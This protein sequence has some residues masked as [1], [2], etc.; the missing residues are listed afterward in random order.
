MQCVAN[1]QPILIRGNN[2]LESRDQGEGHD[3]E[4]GHD[5]KYG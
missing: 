1:G 2:N 3:D 5:K 4:D